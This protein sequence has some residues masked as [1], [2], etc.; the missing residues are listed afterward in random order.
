MIVIP[1][2][3]NRESQWKIPQI[4]TSWQNFHRNFSST[5]STKNRF[6]PCYFCISSPTL[7]RSRVIFRTHDFPR[8]KIILSLVDCNRFNFNQ[9]LTMNCSIIGCS[10]QSYTRFAY[11]ENREKPVNVNFCLFTFTCSF[12]IVF[13]FYETFRQRFHFRQKFFTPRQKVV[14]KLKNRIFRRRNKRT[15]NLIIFYREY[16]TI[17][18]INCRCQTIRTSQDLSTSQLFWQF[19]ITYPS[20][21]VTNTTT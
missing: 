12:L 18:R 6:I 4:I 1:K 9:L 20:Y 14:L 15:L 7:T 10:C 19:R 3:S 16:F 8:N 2:M 13:N 17:R 21:S 11:T 5:I